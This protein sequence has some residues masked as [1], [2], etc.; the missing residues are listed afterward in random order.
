LDK[1]G[2]GADQQGSGA[3]QRE[4]FGKDR[5]GGDGNPGTLIAVPA[6]NPPRRPIR[7]INSAA[8]TVASMVPVIWIATG[9]VDSALSAASVLP[10][11]AAVVPRMAL[12]VIARAW[13]NARSK[14]V[15]QGGGHVRQRR[16]SASLSLA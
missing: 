15:R 11:I 3:E 6:Q 9:R 8:G 14:T 10:T 16:Q 12:P 2:I 5:Q 1:A 13:H 4:G 7:A